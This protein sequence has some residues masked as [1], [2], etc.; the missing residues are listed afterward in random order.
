[1]SPDALETLIM[2]I[3]AKL[4][5]Y[6]RNIRPLDGDLADDFSVLILALVVRSF[7]LSLYVLRK[8]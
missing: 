8:Q 4:R 5:A 7:L 6:G 2:R 3:C 1:M